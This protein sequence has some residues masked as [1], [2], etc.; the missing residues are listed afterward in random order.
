MREC[1][2]LLGKASPAVGY[3]YVEGE[4]K[5]VGEGWNEKELLFN[6]CVG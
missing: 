3:E 2:E 5:E 6:R 4:G 1:T